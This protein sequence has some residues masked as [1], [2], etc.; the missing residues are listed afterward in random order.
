MNKFSELKLF[1]EQV[2]QSVTNTCI[3][4]NALLKANGLTVK[5]PDFRVL[6]D[7]INNYRSELEITF[8][9]ENIFIDVIE[10][11][12]CYN[13]REN[14]KINEVEIYIQSEIDKIL[15]SE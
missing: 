10:F 6:E 15:Q 2:I 14:V 8:W 4:N 12:I 13:G 9:R 11:F 5:G 7:E 3:T 1:E